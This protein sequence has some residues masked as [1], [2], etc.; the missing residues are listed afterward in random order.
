LWNIVIDPSTTLGAFA[1][2]KATATGATHVVV[3]TLPTDQQWGG[4]GNVFGH[5]SVLRYGMSYTVFAHELGH[6]F[7]L[8]H[9]RVTNGS[10]SATYDGNYSYGMV[11]AVRN[12]TTTDPAINPIEQMGDIMSYS[13]RLAPY[14]TSATLNLNQYLAGT[15]WTPLANGNIYIGALGTYAD[16]SS[17]VNL[18]GAAD[19]QPLG[20]PAGQPYACD[21]ARLFRENAAAIVGSGWG[22]APAISAQ[23]ANVTVSVGQ[24]FS[25]TVT[26]VGTGA[27]FTYQWYKGADALGGA[28]AQTYTV[29]NAAP[30]DSGSYHATVVANFAALGGAITLASNSA[31]VTINP[32]PAA[33][34]GSGGGGGGAP[35]DL[36]LVALVFVALV[37]FGST[38]RKR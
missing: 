36:S 12:T 33:N 30:T 28:T 37:R 35:S 1:V 16:P 13:K 2:Q 8:R 32:A 38:F 21:G 3:Y 10:L 25:L 14:F 24:S 23:P 27:T 29:A 17:I 31:T 34:N 4:Y 9:D 7:G 18:S 19:T 22:V 15:K 26:A 20:I 5:Y 11:F 6:N